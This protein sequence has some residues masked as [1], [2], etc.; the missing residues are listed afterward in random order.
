VFLQN[1][2]Y[3][4]IVA[5]NTSSQAAIALSGKRITGDVPL[6]RDCCHR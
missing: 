5:L 2:Y 3:E 6:S 1:W 4:S